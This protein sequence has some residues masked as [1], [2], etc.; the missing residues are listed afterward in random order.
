MAIYK[1]VYRE[2][3]TSVIGYEGE[4]WLMRMCVGEGGKSCT[5]EH[6]VALL[7][8][9]TSRFLLHKWR[10][11]WSDDFVTFVRAFSQ[12]V[13]PR[14]Q[15]GGDLANKNVTKKSGSP[16]ALKRR[17]W[18]CSL[19]MDSIPSQIVT[20][21]IDFVIGKLERPDFFA[22][23][24]AAETDNLKKSHPDGVYVGGNWFIVDDALEEVRAVSVLSD[25]AIV[26][27]GEGLG[28][29][30][31]THQSPQ[32]W[33]RFQALDSFSN[34]ELLLELLRREIMK[35]EESDIE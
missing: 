8:T 5:R 10:D 29:D 35:P 4:L 12:P 28:D 3:D 30:K 27:T 17:E 6:A 34:E 15:A 2:L 11:A 26:S 19:G 13:N 24:W 16:E 9:L 23:N 14:W 21:V 18:V 25:D 32:T 1:S 7:W 22:T 20:A 31:V 33:D